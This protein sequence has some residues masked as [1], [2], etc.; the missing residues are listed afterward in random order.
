[1]TITINNNNNNNDNNDINN[2]TNP[3]NNSTPCIKEPGQ[4]VSQGSMVAPG[5]NV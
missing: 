3:S 1:M 5:E 2:K 4:A